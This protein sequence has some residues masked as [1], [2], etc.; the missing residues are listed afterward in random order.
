MV[1]PKSK[2]SPKKKSGRGRANKAMPVCTSSEGIPP[3]EQEDEETATGDT[4]GEPEEAAE[5]EAREDS[6]EDHD[7]EEDDPGKYM[8]LCVCI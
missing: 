7:L 5:E 1:R 3:G 4:P 2:A 8:H 6:D